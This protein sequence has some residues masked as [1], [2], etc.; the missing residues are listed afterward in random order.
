MLLPVADRAFAT[1][2]VGWVLGGVDLESIP[3][4]RP[5]S[6]ARLRCPLWWR[7]QVAG[8]DERVFV[9]RHGLWS[10]TMDV[11]PHERT[12]SVRL[13]AGPMQR[14]LGLATMHLDS[15]RGPVKPRAANRDALE[16]RAMVDRQVER[17]RAARRVSAG[18]PSGPA[19]AEATPSAS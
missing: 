2:L 4:T 1:A 7:A 15:T 12:Q 13:T 8:S 6:R 19:V 5:P 14:A 11:V 3:L 16:A 17:A 18:A 10:R 9:A